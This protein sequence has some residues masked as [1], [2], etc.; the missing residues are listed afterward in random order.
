MLTG[1]DIAASVPTDVPATTD[2]PA[3]DTPVTNAPHNAV[4]VTADPKVDDTVVVGIP[5]GFKN[6]QA[7]FVCDGM[8]FVA[9]FVLPEDWEIKD[10]RVED[11][12]PY[13][14]D[15]N[16][17]GGSFCKIMYIYNAEG[18]CIGATGCN[19]LPA[20]NGDFSALEEGP[21]AV[22]CMVYMGYGF[23]VD[24]RG[25][26]NPVESVGESRN[27]ISRTYYDPYYV[28]DFVE[29]TEGIY[30]PVI[31]SED[32]ENHHYIVIEIGTGTV[33]DETL[34][35]IAKSVALSIYPA[36]YCVKTRLRLHL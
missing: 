8:D 26:Y 10:E 29:A 34:L 32:T 14:G 4:K 1:D 30:N 21:L 24:I 20:E 18:N 17:T 19:Y 33:S 31:V 13:I 35:T 36:P 9:S 6:Y 2:V 27:A 7:D 15:H 12:F 5:D 11:G 3:A 25:T 23:R 22:Y 28:D 16:G